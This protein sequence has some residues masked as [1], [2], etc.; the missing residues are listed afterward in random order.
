[1]SEE[2][3]KNLREMVHT[4]NVGRLLEAKDRTLRGEVP[5]RPNHVLD[6]ETNRTESKLRRRS[7]ISTELKRT[8]SLIARLRGCRRTLTRRGN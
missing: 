6:A 1:M 4:N 3:E 8:L 2:M 5:K 7:M